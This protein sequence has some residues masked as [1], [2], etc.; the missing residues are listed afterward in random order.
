MRYRE[1]CERQVGR[2]WAWGSTDCMS[3]CRRAVVEAGGPDMAELA[4]GWYEDAEGAM[5][6][7]KRWRDPVVAMNEHG[8]TVGRLDGVADSDIV[9]EP[10]AELGWPHLGPVYGTLLLVAGREQPVRSK[11]VVDARGHALVLRWPR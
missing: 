6:L 7:L 2:E 9:V 10:P 3:L 1:W 4:G 8:W 5:A 11:P